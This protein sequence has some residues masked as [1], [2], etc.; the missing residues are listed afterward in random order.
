MAP[1]RA[2]LAVLAPMVVLAIAGC[3]SAPSAPPSAS[4]PPTSAPTATAV[5]TA[6]STAAPSSAASPTAGVDPAAGLEIAPPYALE[7]PT[8]TDPAT[9]SGQIRGLPSDLAK[10]AGAGH[11]PADFPMGV[12]YIVRDGS[13]IGIVALLPLPADVAALPGLFEAIAAKA[14]AQVSAPIA[15]EEIQGVKVGVVRSPIASTLAIVHDYLVFVQTGQSA[16]DPRD[17]MAA[18]IAANDSFGSS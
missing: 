9:L 2:L 1:P 7:T 13:Q 4:A 11:A 14:A 17:L 18:V 16:I 3:S 15:Y 5:A 12:R 10:Q 8:I 6:A